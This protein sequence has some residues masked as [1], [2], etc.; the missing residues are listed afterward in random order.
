MNSYLTIGEFAKL[1]NVDRK[2]L[3]YYE[4]IGALIPTYTDP[5]TQYRYYKLEQL[6]D[7]DTILM[8]LELEI[9]LKEAAQYKNKDGSLDILRLYNDGKRKANEKLAHLYTIIGRLESATCTMKEN[10]PY[11][12]KNTFY[13][14]YKKKRSIIRVPFSDLGN[15]IAFRQKATDLFVT[16]HQ[17]GYIPMFNFPVG[18]MAEHHNNT[19]KVYVTLEIFSYEYSDNTLEIVYLP[20]GNYLCYQEH[21]A[22]IYHPSSYCLD[23]FAENPEIHFIFLTNMTLDKYEKNIFPL[24]I[25]AF[26]SDQ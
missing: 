13:R 1:R 25:Q 26:I 20:E 5:A 6:V 23:I 10:E 2:S 17:H 18:I 16:A 4:R 3:R 9:P 11:K 21:G 19:L 8:C 12:D 24:E 14:R 15:E 7:L 22:S